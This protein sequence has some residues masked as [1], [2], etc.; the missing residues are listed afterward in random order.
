MKVSQLRIITICKL[1]SACDLLVPGI[2]IRRKKLHK[3]S[4][5]PRR[6]TTSSF[7]QFC[8]GGSVFC[9]I[10]L[11]IKMNILTWLYPRAEQ[12]ASLLISCM[13]LHSTNDVAY[14]IKNI[15]IV[16]I[17]RLSHLRADGGMTYI[18]APVCVQWLRA[19]VL[20]SHSVC[21]RIFLHACVCL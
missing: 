17:C 13:Y 21:V 10:Q 15:Y 8:I 14:R 16:H 4:C 19:P 6:I 20:Y 5:F 18:I 12:I 7:L 3:L 11:A 9:Y 2:I 1:T